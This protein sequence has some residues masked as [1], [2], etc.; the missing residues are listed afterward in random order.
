MR[1]HVQN[2]AGAP[3]PITRATWEAAAERAGETRHEVSFGD[4]VGEFAAAM[5][6]AEAVVGD[7]DVLRPL[8][9]CTAPKLRMIFIC[10]AGVESL[11]PFD[12]LPA[13]VAL[14]NNRG[15]HRVK[16]G[17][18]GIMALLMLVN[19]V[20]EMVTHQRAGRWVPLWGTAAAGRRVTVVGLG[21]LGGE[22]AEQAAR[23]GMRVTGVRAHPEPHPGCE[24]V[25]GTKE[26]DRVLPETEFLVLACPLTPATVGLLDRRR[27]A[28]LPRRAGVVNIGRGR[29]VDQEALCDRLEAG[30]LS[31]VLDVVDP[32]PLPPEHRLWRTPNVVISPHTGTDDPNTY[33]ARSLDIFFENVVALREGR[34]LPTR[35]DVG[36]GY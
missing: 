17:E 33:N 23:L 7:K 19:R 26:L 2:A 28:L 9:P 32:E 10:N 21:T 15:T 22:T 34:E 13:G 35:V 27:I 14:L 25:V 1:I 24:R 29:L 16:A 12:W 18:F 5:A 6:E 11:A 31:A 4:T 8:L 30:E 20:P 3:L 36:R